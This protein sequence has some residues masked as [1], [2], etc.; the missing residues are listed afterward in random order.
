M[1]GGILPGQGDGFGP[2]LAGTSSPDSFRKSWT[3]HGGNRTIP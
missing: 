1:T 3:G 2:N